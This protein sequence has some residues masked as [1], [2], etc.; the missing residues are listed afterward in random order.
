MP[1]DTATL[2]NAVGLLILVL[3]LHLTRRTL[4]ADHRRRRLQATFEHIQEVRPLYDQ[5]RRWVEKEFG[6]DTLNQSDLA[7]IEADPE[8]RETIRSLLALLEH[9]AIGAR[10]GVFDQD[11]WYRMSGTYIIRVFSRLEPYVAFAR[12]D[13]PYAYVEIEAIVTSF[14][15]KKQKS[16]DPRETCIALEDENA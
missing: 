4:I 14:R 16:P 10:V 15:E 3:Q 6:R 12:K 11:L 13:S 2:V 1:L 5:H 9:I 8:A 7:R